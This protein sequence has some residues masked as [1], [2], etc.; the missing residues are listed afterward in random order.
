M[1]PEAQTAPEKGQDQAKAPEKEAQ[2]NCLACGKPLKK[3][4]RYYRNEK[5]YCTK[6]CWKKASRPKQEEGQ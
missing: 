4:K 2:T 3:I 5:Y 1:P 6:K